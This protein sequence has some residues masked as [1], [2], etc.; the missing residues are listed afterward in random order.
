MQLWQALHSFAAKRFEVRMETIYGKGVC[1]S[2]A[3]GRLHF[4]KKRER[5]EAQQ[6]AED[7]NAE[8]ARFDGAVKTALAQ[9]ATLYKETA[10]RA[11]EE[12][13]Q[14]FEVHRMMLADED[15]LEYVRE[16]IEACGCTATAAVHAAGAHFAELF[17][18]MDDPYMQAR[19]ADIHDISSRVVDILSDRAENTEQ[20]TEPVILVAEDLSPSET[21]H[22]AGA[23]I[24]AF[25]TE[26]GSENSHT[27]ILA[28]AMQIPAVVSV[29]AIDDKNQG[30]YAI[31]DGFC[32]AVYLNPDAD[33][34]AKYVQKKQEE[35]AHRRAIDALRGMPNLTR[36][37]VHVELYANIGGVADVAAAL[38]NDAGGIGLF[39]SEFLYLSNT[40]APTE[41][42]QF[43]AYRTVLERM[44]GKRVIVRTLDIGADKQVKYFDLPREENPALGCRAL[45]L[46]LAR[47]KLFHTQLR[48]LLRASVYGT[49]SI[50]FPMVASVWEV[51][52][53]KK[54]LDEARAELEQEGVRMAE[55]VGVGIM[56]ETPA[57]ALISDLL[58]PEVD[59]FSIGTNDLIQYT[60]AVDRQNPLLS[61]HCDPRH[62]AVLRLIAQTAEAAHKHGKWVGICGELAADRSL[63]A[64]FLKMGIDELSVS[65]SF[66]LPL[67]ETVRSMTVKEEQN[68]W[69]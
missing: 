25:V 30:S 46:C 2:I 45:R 5:Q 35:E 69:I 68:V 39:R 13:A 41:E 34:I 12:Q 57:A 49:L 32:G 24:L 55:H 20:L 38:E 42:E 22:L 64:T 15:Y 59:F 40:H 58:A 26:R 10:W 62:E 18:A 43:V 31:V 60:L 51:R 3:M 16:Q 1:R 21:M 36:D 7:P 33:T 17:T 8:L 9:L 61:A 52:E 6:T 44:K 56:I 27:A 63:T 53:A 23:N 11:G 54:A 50:M 47:P 37:G 19:A 67:R 4:L 29:G 65:P 66:I 28:R 14:I 48:A